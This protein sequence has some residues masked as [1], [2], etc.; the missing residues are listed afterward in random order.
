M[1]LQQYKRGVRF[2]DIIDSLGPA[3]FRKW[4]EESWS[5]KSVRRRDYARTWVVAV[6]VVVSLLSMSLS[7]PR[8]RIHASLDNGFEVIWL[9]ALEADVD[10]VHAE[11]LHRGVTPLDGAKASVQLS[12]ERGPKSADIHLPSASA[13]LRGSRGSIRSSN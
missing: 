6:V 11:A 10:H 4:M 7:R 8:P 13:T 3:G 1:E 5:G 9:D 12:P 2:I